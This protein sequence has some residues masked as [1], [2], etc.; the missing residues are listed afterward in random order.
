MRKL[1]FFLFALLASLSTARA[2]FGDVVDF[3]AM[4]LDTDYTLNGDF[5]DYKGSLTPT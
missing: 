2:G 1:Y 5:S 4:N 3:G